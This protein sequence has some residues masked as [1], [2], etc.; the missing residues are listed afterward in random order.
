M[1]FKH[2]EILYALFALLIPVFIHL[3]QLQRFIKTPFTNVKFLKEI[4]LQTRKSSRLK[5]W[6]ILFSRLG[7]FASLIVAFAQPYFSKNDLSKDW[8]TVLYLD[9]SMSM[10]T[11]GERGELL[12]RAVQDISE[13][14]SNIGNYTLLT[15][16]KNYNNLS[17][18]ALIKQIKTIDYSVTSLPVETALLKVQ[19]AYSKAQDKHKKTIFISDFQKE[20]SEKEP[21]ISQTETIDFVQVK[22]NINF[23]V[24]IDNVK[25]KEVIGDIIL[26]EIALTHQ[27][28]DKV[29]ISLSALQD[30]MVL[31]KNSFEIEANKQ[32]SIS[33]RVP[34]SV[35][36]VVIKIAVDD[37]FVY[38]NTYY[39][40]FNQQEKINVLAVTNK[41][42]FL[43]K[44]YTEKEFN[45]VS[46]KISEIS[47]ELIDKQQ[48]VV[49]NGLD[50]PN[51]YAN[52]L[53]EYVKNGGSIVLIPNKKDKIDAINRLFSQLQIGQI[54]S[55]RSDTLQ[56]TKIHFSHPIVKNVFDKRVT[57]FQYP[58][59]NNYFVG[60]LQNEQAILSFE[61]KSSFITQINKGKGSVFWVASPLDIKS[62]NFTKAPLIVPVF[63]NIAKQ[64]FP[65][66]ILSYRVGEPN[67]IAIKHKLQKDEVIHIA[68]EN[69]NF[70]PRQEI[71][72][73]KVLLH[74][75]NKPKKTGFYQIIDQNKQLQSIA[76]NS[77]KKESNFSY[78]K[79]ANFSKN[80]F[81]SLNKALK[82]L[83]DD[84]SIQSYFKW[85]VLLALL[86]ILLE[87]LLIK[88]L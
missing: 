32:K 55:K 64:S 20:I 28:E 88:Y 23:N 87:I 65:Q 77:P 67:L 26:L 51:N 66:N 24:S 40:S 61:N 13:N 57:N 9:N 58:K 8:L 43:E 2:P 63:Y 70:I 74:T 33:I 16:D 54:L 10:Q 34:K 27:G 86:F 79:L 37:A 21:T 48:L 50:I 59:V 73:D 35:A 44:I 31:A 49:F 30:E 82:T 76:F 11:K 45:Y 75:L 25:I 39:I 36:N 29:T 1:Q 47:F 62:T 41:Q 84:Q 53:S 85:F 60:N 19:E 72:A 22:H 17:K 52:K 81:N 38:D 15:N 4:E 83:T 42:V 46:K 18:Q 80:N 7:I 3:F 56:V 71:H 69:Y 68:N 5:K 14:I 6:L 12:K 78:Y